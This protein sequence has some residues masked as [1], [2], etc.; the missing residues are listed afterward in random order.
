MGTRTNPP[1]APPDYSDRHL[2]GAE[3]SEDIQTYANGALSQRLTGSRHRHELPGWLRAPDPRLP[4]ALLGAALLAYGLLLMLLSR[5]FG[6]FQDEYFWILRRRAWNVNAF[7][8]PYNGHLSAV[9][10][11]IYKLLFVTV[12]LQ[13]TWP[14]RLILV[15]LHLL[16]VVLIYTLAARRAGRWL[17]LIPAFLLLGLGAGYEDLLFAIGMGFVGA[18]AA[19]LAALLCLE[20]RSRRG[21]VAAAALVLVALASTSDGLAVAVAILAELLLVRSPWRRL[22]IALGPLALYV[23]WY[24]HFGT[25]EASL[26]NVPLIPSRDLE[27]GAYGF[28]AFGGLTVGYG[29]ILLAAAVGYLL[30]RARHGHPPS[31]RT[32][33]GIA[34][35][36]TF[37][38]LTVLARAQYDEPGASRYVYISAVFILIAA[39]GTLEWR[40]LSPAVWASVGIVIALAWLSNLHPLTDYAKDRTQVD[41]EVRAELGAAEVVGSAASPGFQPDVHHLPWM[42]LGE[43][44]AAVKDLGSP[45]FTPRQIAQEPEDNRELADNVML[46]AESLS[47]D[48]PGAEGLHTAVPAAI[49]HSRGMLIERVPVAG[50]PGGC[51]RLTPSIS[52]GAANVSVAPCH[53]LYVSIGGTGLLSIHAHRFASRAPRPLRVVPAARTPAVLRFPADSLA[54]PWHVRLAPTTPTTICLV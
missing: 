44:L 50:T 27:T 31:A 30:I 13:H 26:S 5:H 34:G 1:T 9:P 40:R 8:Q 19:G 53:A 36:V 32:I 29:Q 52:G 11:T 10:L 35:A 38:T 16:C 49:L 18:L 42:H 45:A 33:A 3:P 15:G 24:L 14:Y 41:A 20:S 12:G 23:V 51:T 2:R 4:A 17:A 28:A 25:N 46:D 22:W 37:W 48:Q 39:V 54:L 47:L 6:F 7:W 43:Y 21:D